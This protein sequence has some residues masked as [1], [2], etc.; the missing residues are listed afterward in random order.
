MKKTLGLL[1]AVCLIL[2]MAAGCGNTGT[3]SAA[4]PA[5]SVPEAAAEENA[6][7]ASDAPEAAEAPEAPD[8]AGSAEEGSAAEEPERAT[9]SYPVTTDVVLTG[10]TSWQPQQGSDSE[11]LNGL[12][13][14]IKYGE[15]VGITVDFTTGSWDSYNSM[16]QL[17]MAA[18]DLPDLCKNL[19]GV[20]GNSL[21][22]LVEQGVLM[23][24]TELTPTYAPDFYYT[25]LDYGVYGDIATAEGRIV[26]V[27]PLVV[28]CE[29]IYQTMGPFI[30]QDY[31]DEQKLQAPTTYDEYYDVLMKLKSAYNLDEAFQLYT[32][33]VPQSD[34]LVSGYGAVQDGYI[35]EDGTVS[36]SLISDG[37]KEYLT[38]MHNWFD[39]GLINTDFISE[40]VNF[41]ADE[42]NSKIVSGH[43]AIAYLD[44]SFAANMQ[45]QYNVVLT[46]ITDA[47]GDEPDHLGPEGDLVAGD[48]FGVS[49]NSKHP[50]VALMWLN[51][52]FSEEGYYTAN[53]GFEGETYV[54]D[55]NGNPQWTEMMTNDPDGRTIR[56]MVNLATYSGGSCRYDAF[57]LASDTDREVMKVWLSTKD[58]EN[59]YPKTVQLTAEESSAY[60]AAYSDI[61]T[62]CA[63]SVLQFI[64]GEKDLSEFDSYVETVKGMGIDDCVAIKQT[65]YDRYCSLGEE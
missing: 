16:A 4:E 60:T 46:P 25:L 43:T 30:R 15:R 23:D 11:T 40:N 36:Y 51:Y 27:P 5:A 65:A 63:E 50:D 53:Y 35:V 48:G 59:R 14:F 7:E 13:S 32:S 21:D 61:E 29:D 10:M 47:V 34:Y 39:S 17:M 9:I 18:G 64:T 33:G 57:K 56:T 49:A 6:P 58:H 52:G 38:M 1:L 19:N 2:S 20:S 42:Y 3:S 22:A 28:G 12:R 26:Q 55:E 41:T 31:L 45:N 24:L 44:V 37:F 54:I 62:Y 8:A